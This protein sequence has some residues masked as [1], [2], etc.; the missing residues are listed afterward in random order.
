MIDLHCDTLLISYLQKRYDMEDLPGMVD[1]R[2]MRAGGVTAQVFAIFMLPEEMAQYLPGRRLPDDWEYIHALRKILADNLAAHG[3]QAAF[4]KSA[5]DIRRNKSAGKLSALLSIEDGR[6]LNGDLGGVDK[7][8]EL[9]IR[10]SGITWNR[11]NCL[12]NPGGAGGEQA[13]LTPFGK[14]AVRYMQ[15][16]GMIVDVSHLSDQGFWDVAD[17]CRKPFIATHSNCRAV[18]PHPRNLSDDMLR[19]LADHGGVAGVNFMPEALCR[20]GE[21]QIGRVDRIVEMIRHVKNVAGIGAAAIGT[22]FD[23]FVGEQEIP[24]SAE[25]Y[26]LPEA[27][28]KGGFSEAEIDQVLFQNVLRVMEATL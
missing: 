4:A 2:R 3:D 1:F 9:G 23:G 25:M 10:I 24:S 6:A 17:I 26:R 14:D 7:L 12:G 27:L 18:C 22:D 28:K 11:T 20:E 5:E 21:K 8:Y 19:A 15:E 16:K 13:G